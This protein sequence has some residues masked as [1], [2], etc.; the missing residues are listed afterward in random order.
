MKDKTWLLLFFFILSFSAHAF[1]SKA[2]EASSASITEQIKLIEQAVL[3]FEQT[4]RKNWAYQVTRYEN[5][6]GDITSSI[7]QFTP[8]LAVENQ[9]LLI[10]INGQ[11]PTVKQT[12][13]FVDKKVRLANKKGNKS[14]SLALSELVNLES[15]EFSNEN[16]S[17][18]EMNFDVSIAKLGDDAKGKLK[19]KLRYHKQL[20]FIEQ[21]SIVNNAEFSPLFS[22][23]IT[24]FKMSFNF[25]NINDNILLKQQAMDMKGSFAFFTEINETSTDTFSDYK[26]IDIQ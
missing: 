1:T 23:N 6:E 26:F 7:E 8:A 25:T 13:D 20:A 19:G 2:N 24:D 18:I 22:A 5:E 10:Q 21:I 17:Y 12:Q 9:W 3:K 11:Q 4:P 16:S 15:L 14:L